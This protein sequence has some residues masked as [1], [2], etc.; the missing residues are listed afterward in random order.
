MILNN[1]EDYF[2][3][4]ESE[5]L[6]FLKR[7]EDP[8]QLCE[9]M[10]AIAN[11]NG[12]LIIIGASSSGELSDLSNDDIV[13]T[14]RMITQV[15][16]EYVHPSIFCKTQIETYQNSRIVMIQ[17]PPGTQK[18][19]CTVSG[20][21]LIKT[22]SNNIEDIDHDDLR[23]LFSE[24]MIF[25]ADQMIIEGSDHTYINLENF[26]QFFKNKFKIDLPENI[27]LITMLESMKLA[28][29]G[30]V[31]TSGM[32]LFGNYPNE[33]FSLSQI[34]AM[35]FY[36]NDTSVLEYRDSDNYEGTIVE[37]FHKGMSFIYKN[38]AEPMKENHSLK[39]IPEIII[40]EVLINALV[41][42]SYY[43]D[44]FTSGN[45]V[46]SVFDNRVEIESP[47]ALYETLT[48]ERIQKGKAFHRNATI[49]NY[50]KD[51]LPFRGIG[52]GI[53]TILSNYQGIEFIDDDD[54]DQFKVI[55]NRPE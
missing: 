28:S 52:L 4:G 25:Q 32:L 6:S 11:V 51:L 55:I 13:S 18:P 16:F 43:L 10:V 49:A 8:H 47:G 21:F 44:Y 17:I 12:G 30:Q 19:Y 15:A 7:I 1:L 27:P 14:L 5:N 40:Q 39:E 41:H 29:N 34:V 45:I 33:K 2:K 22:E 53:S 24:K 9:Q 3:Q 37:L 48:I 42:R 46:L 35:S 38:L 20:Q 36:G 50:L 23:D 54:S 31:N 26:Q